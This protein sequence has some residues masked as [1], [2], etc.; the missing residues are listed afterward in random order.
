MPG[1]VWDDKKQPGRVDFKMRLPDARIALPN[2][3]A[4]PFTACD[5]P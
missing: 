5:A 3:F 4:L 2:R 1:T